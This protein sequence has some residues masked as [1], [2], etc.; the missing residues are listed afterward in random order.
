MW[1]RYKNKTRRDEI[2]LLL[3]G[4]NVPQPSLCTDEPL[5]SAKD[6]PK[7]PPRGK[8]P[9]MDL[10][11]REVSFKQGGVKRKLYTTDQ[12]ASTATASEKE[13]ATQSLVSRTEA[14]EGII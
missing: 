1:L 13:T 12:P 6:K 8:Q 5:P 10:P 4:L 11:D 7:T 14:L 9:P 3:Q 2:K